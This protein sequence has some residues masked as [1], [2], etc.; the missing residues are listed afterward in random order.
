VLDGSCRTPIGGHARVRG[1]TVSLRGMIVAPDGSAAFEVFREGNRV[2]A[3]QLGA[4]AGHELRSR[5]GADF[6]ALM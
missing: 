2:E 3:A 5:A 6:F 1:E 4:D